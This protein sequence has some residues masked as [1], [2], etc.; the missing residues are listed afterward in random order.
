MDV[1]SRVDLAVIGGGAAGLAAAQTAAALGA[2]TLLVEAARLGGECTWNG[3]VPSKSL[4]ET[5][6]LRHDAQRAER[7]G[8]RVGEVTVDFPAV[9]RHVREVV[10][11][12]ATYEDTEHLRRAGVEVVASRA[13]LVGPTTLDIAGRHVEARR[14][15][16]CSGSRPA[17][18]PVPGLDSVA[19]L[20]NETLWEL[21]TQPQRLAVLGAGPVGLEMAQAFTRLGSEVTVL[22]VADEFLPRED[23]EIAGC[24]RQL[25]EAEGIR[26]V[27]GAEITEVTQVGGGVM[28]TARLPDGATEKVEADGL[29]VATGRT[30]AVAG[31]GLEEVGVEVRRTGIAV[32]AHLRTAVRSIY[33]AGDVTGILP[34]THAAAYQARVAARH[35]VTGRGS[36]DHRVVPWIVFTDPEIAHVGLTEPE[37]RRLHG[38]IRV[39]RLPYTAVDRAVIH[40]E[41]RGMLKVVTRRK[42]VLGHRGGGE[43]VGAHL[44]GPGAGELVHEF[45]L[46]MQ[47]RAFAGRLAQTIHAYP[48]MALGV[49]QV[50]AQLFPLGRA[51]AGDLREDLVQTF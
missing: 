5:A 40:R 31:L 32:D 50:V 14:I 3:C 42:P 43:L 45:A 46:A 27:L 13:R 12:I 28:L 10:G 48:A 26:F 8:I 44:V 39:A 19:H 18:P 41:V 17:I 47:T 30:P 37:A 34:F 23:P 16:V 20:T 25:L 2:R 33:A 36:A 22:D 4:I 24:A 51:T 29:L 7:F 35:A 38:D 9:M 1:P 6:R 49:Q 15:V 11:A 21:N